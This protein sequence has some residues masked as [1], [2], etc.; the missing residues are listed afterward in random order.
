MSSVQYTSPALWRAVTQAGYFVGLSGAIGATVT[1]AAAVR[2]VLR[3]P[4]V[5]R[6][7]VE[8]LRRRM[9]TYLAW[10]G[11]VLLF[12]G[13]GQL[14]ARV[15]RA[16]A[17]MPFGSALAPARI[18]DF[19]TAPA[20]PGDWVAGGTLYLVQNVVLLLA[21]ATLMALFSAAA[22]RHLD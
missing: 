1:Y 5:D 17:G 11:V 15:A 21:G 8:V 16:G 9:A 20:R 10:S 3:G 12:A 18:R 2:P 19:L 4:A 6:S 7:D 22:R 13:Y 14:A